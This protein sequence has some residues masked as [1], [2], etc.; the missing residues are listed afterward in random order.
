MVGLNACSAKMLDISSKLPADIW[1]DAKR[2]NPDGLFQYV[3]KP[4]R[5]KLSNIWRL[6]SDF[7]KTLTTLWLYGMSTKNLLICDFLFYFKEKKIEKYFA[8]IS[9][10]E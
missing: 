3:I 4:L 10:P 5:S 6:S 8:E 2:F 7:G 9:Y 1:M